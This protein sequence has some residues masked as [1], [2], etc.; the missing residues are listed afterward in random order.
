[1]N[2]PE[3]NILYFEEDEETTTVIRK[4]E[5]IARIKWLEKEILNHNPTISKNWD[6]RKLKEAFKEIVE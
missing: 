2:K 5:L 6:L 1:M 3:L 4:E